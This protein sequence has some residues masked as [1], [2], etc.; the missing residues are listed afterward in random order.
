M[1]SSPGAPD[2]HSVY[3]NSDMALA[4]SDQFDF[5]RQIFDAQPDYLDLGPPID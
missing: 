3:Y 5:D 2:L 1:L 4:S